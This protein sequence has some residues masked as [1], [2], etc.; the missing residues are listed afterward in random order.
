MLSLIVS[1]SGPFNE[2]LGRRVFSFSFSMSIFR[3]I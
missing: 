3:K 2:I 1:V